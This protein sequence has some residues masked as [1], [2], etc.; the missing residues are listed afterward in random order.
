MAK[1]KLSPKIG[2]GLM[3]YGN[4]ISASTGVHD[5]LYIRVVVLDDGKNKSVFCSIEVC[6]LRAPQVHEIRDYV[7]R[8]SDLLAENIFY[9]DDSYSL[10]ACCPRY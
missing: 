3:G 7:T 8:Q 1:Q 4:R 6:Y 5:D 9:Y 10:S 2:S